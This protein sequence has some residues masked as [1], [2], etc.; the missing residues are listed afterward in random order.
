MIKQSIPLYAADISQFSRS[1]A[2]QL[3]QDVAVPS[4]LSLMNMLARAAGFR[5]FQH[6][7]AAHK[8][9]QKM[10]DSAETAQ[11]DHALV[12]RCLQH[13]DAAGEMHRWPSRRRV[14]ENC[15]WLFW[16]ALP[17]GEHLHEREVNALLDQVH[18]FGDAAL[19]RRMMVGLGL[20][21]RNRDGSDYLRVEQKPPAEAVE[22]IRRVK[23]RRGAQR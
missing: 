7:R 11:M 4:H 19:L 20:L 3:S 21:T 17:K 13:I 8:S 1:L 12:S 16:A 6:M 14:Q 15:I 5:N 2:K 22:L 23:A 10:A 9:G 18:S